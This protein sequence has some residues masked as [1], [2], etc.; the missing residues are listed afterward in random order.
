VERFAWELHG[1]DVVAFTDA[2]G[3]DA[4]DTVQPLPT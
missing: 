4:P 2:H 1:S 3:S